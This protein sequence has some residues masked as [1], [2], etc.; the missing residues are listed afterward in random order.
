MLVVLGNIILFVR[1]PDLV[2]EREMKMYRQGGSDL[3][4]ERKSSKISCKIFL[5][6]SDFFSLSVRLAI[7][8]FLLLI[9][10]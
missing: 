10:Y 5:D 4:G 7:F 2:R 1:C 9:Y 6:F 8:I 3:V